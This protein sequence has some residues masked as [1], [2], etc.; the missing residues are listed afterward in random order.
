MDKQLIWNNLCHVKVMGL[1]LD[2]DETQGMESFK[3]ASEL[4]Q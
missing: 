1:I 2:R 3:D 4:N